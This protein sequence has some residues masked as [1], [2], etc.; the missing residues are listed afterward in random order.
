MDLIL[1]SLI[2]NPDFYDDRL[3]VV[4]SAPPPATLRNLICKIQQDLK[5]VASRTFPVTVALCNKTFPLMYGSDIWLAPPT[6][7][8]M[9]ALEITH[10]QTPDVVERL[11]NELRDAIPE[12]TDFTFQHRA[13]V[14][15]PMLSYDA[16]AIA[17]SFV[18]AAGEG[19]PDDTGRKVE[20]DGYTF[21][22]FRR[23]LYDISVSAGVRPASRY[24]VPTAHITIGR[25]VTNEDFET[26][27][28]FDLSKMKKWIEKIEEINAWLEGDYWPGG[29]KFKDGGEWIIGQET[30][31][32][33]RYRC[34]Y[35]GGGD[36]ARLGRGF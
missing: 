11:L 21:N 4:F 36:M 19:L 14:I 33:C 2:A 32:D 18:P 25:F 17:L 31:L 10:T 23:D 15:K 16:A 34:V 26:E 29:V 12:L 1:R 20:D 22:H 28:E 6:Y 27:G 30:G 3:G 8:H 5:T 24:V 13:R 7:L 35:Y 9:T